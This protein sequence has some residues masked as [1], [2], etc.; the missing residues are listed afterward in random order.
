VSHTRECFLDKTQARVLVRD[1]LDGS[2][3]HR[4]IWRFHLDP[5]IGAC[6]DG[7]DV[8]L[9]G[10]SGTS[11]L[12]PS[13]P[14]GFQPSLEPGWVSPSYGVKVPT[15]VLVWRAS[16]RLPIVGSYLFAESRLAPD[17]RT[18]VVEVLSASE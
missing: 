9:S 5:A 3:E 16:A 6:I 2:G 12:L 15:T 18:S 8:R 1:R 10:D 7:A 11:W 14:T 17:E 13:L 4:V